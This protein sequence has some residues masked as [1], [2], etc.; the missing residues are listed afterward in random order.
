M[1]KLVFVT[2]A[3]DVRDV[4]SRM[5]DFTIADVLGAQMPWGPFM[6]GID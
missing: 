5:E 1:G 2:K 6:L 3:R 4:V